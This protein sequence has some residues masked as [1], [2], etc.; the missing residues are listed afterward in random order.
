MK[1]SVYITS[2]NQKTY[3]NEALQSVLNQTL[4]PFEIIIID[5]ASDDGSQDLISNYCIKFPN[6]IKSVFN[7]ENKGISA[8]R[9]IALNL[10]KGDYTTWLDGDDIYLPRK[11]EV[12]SN[13]IKKGGVNLVYTNYYY[14]KD[15]ISNLYQIW[16]SN[17]N[18]ITKS[19]NI[20]KAVVCRNFP[21]S[22]LFRYELVE[23]K[24]LKSIGGYDENLKIYEDFDFR[25]RL[26]ETANT[27]FSFEPLIVY[28]IHGKGLSNASKENHLISLNYIYRKY[29]NL[30]LNLPT[31]D[32][33]EIMRFIDR[34]LSN[35]NKK[36]VSLK[37]KIK[38]KLKKIIDR[39]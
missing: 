1:I 24:M 5:D 9:N 33:E 4:M 20:F 7:P 22:N 27:T 17:I 38:R 15:D 10:V 29:E 2:Y 28:R 19:K 16:C 21:M 13:L 25:I 3:L 32:R 12:Q 23:T 18:E 14:A 6:L 36:P 35:F 30:F 39:N 31:T 34:N 8:C 37:H 26:C 11:L